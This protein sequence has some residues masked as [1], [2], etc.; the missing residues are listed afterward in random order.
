MKFPYE[1]KVF[2]VIM[3]STLLIFSS[4]HFG[5]K[6]FEGIISKTKG[7]PENTWI[8]PIDASGLEK[9]EVNQELVTKVNEWQTSSSIQ[10]LFKET[11]GL[12]PIE[13]IIFK[14]DESVQFAKDSVKNELLIDI[15][16]E[17]IQKVLLS[18]SPA[19]ENNKVDMVKLKSHL[20]TE[21][22]SLQTQAIDI[23]IEDFLS[24][25]ELEEQIVHTVSIPVINDDLQN[26]GATLMIEPNG[27]F[28]LLGFLEKQ[29]LMELDSSVIDIVSSG[30]YQA[31]LQTNLEILERHIGSELPE[32]IGLG[33]EAKV[34]ANLKWDLSI[35]NPNEEKYKIEI[36]S[37]G[38]SLI[39]D[40]IGLPFLYEYTIMQEGL[41]SFDPKTIKQ[42]NPL[43][44]PGQTKITKNGQKGYYLE[45]SRLIL[46]ETGKL[47]EQQLVSKDYYSP[48]HQVVVFGLGSKDS[49]LTNEDNNPNII[50]PEETPNGSND[51]ENTVDII[52]PEEPVTSNEDSEEEALWGRSDEIEK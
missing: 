15:D 49:A 36:Y 43:L 10:L 4:S 3:L 35:Y 21:I 30:I 48:V 28:S 12:I 51:L 18:I 5:V 52:T 50:L 44:E 42:Y 9:A 47:V 14:V 6:A 46:D 13:E 17:A 27:T 2:S 20:I 40:V 24:M 34:N 32:Y 16:D 39:F 11:N 23:N 1:L 25:P 7:F 31:I 41:Q 8:G 45:V 38:K 19:F 37:D 22:S 26:I 33:Y 29:G